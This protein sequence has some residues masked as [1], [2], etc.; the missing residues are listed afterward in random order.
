MYIHLN[1]YLVVIIKRF[2]FQPS[3]AEFTVFHMECLPGFRL[4]ETLPPRNVCKCAVDIRE[5]LSCDPDM[6]F[7]LLK[8]SASKIFWAF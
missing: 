5:V 1:F 3:T 8:V 7:V 6:R 4:D 2:I